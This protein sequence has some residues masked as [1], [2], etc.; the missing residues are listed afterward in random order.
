MLK[1]YQEFLNENKSS[2]EY[3][4]LERQFISDFLESSSEL[5]MGSFSRVAQNSSSSKSAVEDFQTS[6]NSFEK[7]Y[8][9]RFITATVRKYEKQIDSILYNRNNDEFPHDTQHAAFSDMFLHHFA[10]DLWSLGGM[11]IQDDVD[12]LIRYLYGWHHTKYGRMAILDDF[13]TM[14][15]YF[16]W[17]LSEEE[18][19]YALQDAEDTVGNDI[20]ICKGDNADN[21]IWRYKRDNEKI[22][23]DIKIVNSN[24]S[25]YYAVVLTYP[26]NPKKEEDIEKYFIDQLITHDKTGYF[27]VFDVDTS[28]IDDEKINQ[29]TKNAKSMKK[30]N[31]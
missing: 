9:R 20:V 24:S 28:H 19:M 21:V 23:S 27:S 3:T 10:P 6:L 29:L 15:K 16:E 12:T 2:V 5:N 7:K 25:D 4:D 17:V 26:K 31:I 1:S 18:G 22:D 13:G 14:D 11:Y 8:G 30:Y